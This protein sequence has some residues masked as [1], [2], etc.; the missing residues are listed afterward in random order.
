MTMK[1][2]CDY[3]IRTRRERNNKHRIEVTRGNY[4]GP[5][6]DK[7]WRKV[8]TGQKS[9]YSKGKSYSHTKLWSAQNLSERIHTMYHDNTFTN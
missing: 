9:T 2:A 6:T 3:A 1:E 4:L 5:F 7:E 8:K